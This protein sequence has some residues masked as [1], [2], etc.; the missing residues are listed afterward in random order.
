MNS[1]MNDVKQMR[2]GALLS[3]GKDSLYAAWKVVQMGSDIA[4]FITIRSKNAESY[5]FHT[6][7]ISLTR[8]QAEASAIPLIEQETEGI[9]EKE[10]LDLATS[11]HCASEKFHL[12][13]IVT[14]A[15]QSVYQATRIERI[16]HQEGLWCIS[17]LWQCDQET[18]VRSLADEGFEVIVAGVFADSLDASWLGTHI[19]RTFVDRLKKVSGKY[20]ISIA[21]EGGEYESFV[22]NAPFFKKRIIIEKAEILFKHGAGNYRIIS[23]GLV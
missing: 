12:D 19:D 13:G 15:I 4:C 6:P 17:P 11:I 14:G 23:A 3:G 18:Y 21:G 20:Q 10:L 16:C 2:F 9:E 22:L 7:N 1:Q 8:L 5:M